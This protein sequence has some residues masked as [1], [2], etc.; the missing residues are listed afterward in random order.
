MKNSEFRLKKD[1]DDSL[2]YRKGY[3]YLLYNETKQQYDFH[4]S[5]CPFPWEMIF[6]E[7]QDFDELIPFLT[8]SFKARGINF[9]KPNK[10]LHS[11]VNR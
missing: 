3:S 7:G 1:R 6:N 10:S 8:D 5:F 4:H 9:K 2:I 11:A